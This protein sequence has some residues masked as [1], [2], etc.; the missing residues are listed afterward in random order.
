VYALR[1]YGYEGPIEIK[2]E[3]LPAGVHCAGTTIGTKET[4]S[5]LIFRADENAPEA[6]A[7]LKLISTAS[8]PSPAAQRDYDAAEKAI[9]DAEKGLP[10]LR[11]KADDARAKLEQAI[12]QRDE[13]AQAVANDP[14]NAGLK[15]QL[16]QREQALAPLQQQYQQAADA[17][18]AIEKTLVEARQKLTQAEL[19]RKLG[20]RQVRH[21]VRNGA[22]MIAGQSN[23]PSEGRLAQSFLIAVLRESAHFE[24]RA[25]VERVAAAQ[26]RQILAPVQ[27]VKRHGFDDKVTLTVAGIPKNSNLQA[28]N[29][30]IEKGK[31]SGVVS[32][33]VASNTPPGTYSLWLTAQGQV[34]YSRN[35]ERTERLR[36]ERDAAAE[37]LKQAQEAQ[38][39]ATDAKTAA[40]QKATE[41]AAALQQ[42]QQKKQ[43]ADQ[44]VTQATKARDDLKPT[45]EAAEKKVAEEL[46]KAV[47]DAEA[48][49]KTAQEALAG[50]SENADLKAAVAK[51]EEAVVAAKKALEEGTTQRDELVKKFQEAERLLAEATTAQTGAAD[52]Q[53]QA[54]AAKAAADKA[55]AD[56]EA[57]EK[58]AVDAAKQADDKKKAA[59]KRFDDADKASKPQNKN[60]QPVSTPIVFDVVPAPV[61]LTATVANGGAVKAGESVEVTVKIE[62]LNRFAGPVTISVPLPPGVAGLS[63]GVEIPADQTEAKFQLSAAADATEGQLAQM[64]I[65][66]AAEWNGQQL[67]DVPAAIKV[68]R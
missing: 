20:Q 7:H 11:K 41:A 50:D 28:P 62:R 21:L 24:I 48:A 32:V 47:A 56:A 66:A 29:V 10:D 40:T 35:P 55:K 16:A 59:D 57:A 58:A 46:A 52:G 45:K 14:A 63:G 64:V 49:L 8:I 12:Q 68:S 3:G 15:Q 23:A 25:A 43:Q 54:E 65:R 22:I 4:M 1:K 9:T 26:S 51:A 44:A 13:S 19:Q 2:V 67:V 36:A 38:K 30:T 34:S 6:V 60:Y 27:L 39:Q 5:Q 42:A 18:A 61:K 33:F 37:R 17:L 31:D 53:T